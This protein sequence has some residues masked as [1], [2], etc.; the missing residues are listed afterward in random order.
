MKSFLLSVAMLAAVLGGCGDKG[1]GGSSPSG[2]GGGGGG[3]Y[4]GSGGDGSDGA[5]AVYPGGHPITWLTTDGWT[6]GQEDRILELVNN[7]R[8]ASSLGALTMDLLMRQ[9]SRGH[10]VHMTSASHNFF[11]HVNPEGDGPSQRYVLAGG[12]GGCG[13]NIAAG[14][15]DADAAFAGWMASP[16]HYANIHTAGYTK[17]G[18]GYSGGTITSVGPYTKVYTQM[19]Q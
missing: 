18:T 19:F 9:T 11:A 17:T 6:L 12:T 14:Y 13:E 4:P 2:G 3:P 7:E 10:S 1:G 16:G 8:V 15:A 5:G